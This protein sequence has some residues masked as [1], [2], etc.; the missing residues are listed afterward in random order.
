MVDYSTEFELLAEA[1][2]ISGGNPVDLHNNQLGLL[3]VS[4]NKILGKNEIPGLTIEG[5]S[6]PD[7]VKAKIRVAQNTR[8]ENP[9][10]LCFGVIPAEG[11]QRIVADFNIEDGGSATFVAHCSFPNAVKVQHIME[12]IV[13]I[14]K[15]AAMEYSETHYHGAEGRVQVLP[16]MKIYIEQNGRYTSTF[17][18]IKGAAGVI[19]LDYEAY[20]GERAVAEMYA[21]IYGKRHDDIQVKESIYLNGLESRGLAKSRI[22][23]SDQARAI[24]LGEVVG[25]GAYSRGHIDCLE[26]IQGKEALA[27]AVPKLQVMDSTAK[28]A[29]EAAIGSVDKRQVETL[30]ARGLS[31]QEA[32]D[33]IVMGLLK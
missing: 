31:E 18:L 25:K 13:K 14:G 8:I 15:N 4:S 11:V 28:L 20:L 29:H 23:L 6:L 5:E 19:N 17:R 2:Q 22:V 33:V 7:G 12:G 3:L 1:Y 26:I 16:N 21:K 32:V 9:V 27:A 30:M 10:H 24:V